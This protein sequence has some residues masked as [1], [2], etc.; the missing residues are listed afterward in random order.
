MTPTVDLNAILALPAEQRLV[1]FD[2]IVKS[3]PKSQ[4]QELQQS[5]DQR[6]YSPWAYHESEVDCDDRQR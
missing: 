6:L 3:L 5:L 4:S 1:V 2:A